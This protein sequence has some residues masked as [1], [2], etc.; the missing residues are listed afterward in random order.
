MGK[1]LVSVWAGILECS[2][3]MGIYHGGLVSNTKSYPRCFLAKLFL[4]SA[5]ILYAHGINT[6]SFAGNPL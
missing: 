6:L 2:P 3:K 1:E 5:L 4:D